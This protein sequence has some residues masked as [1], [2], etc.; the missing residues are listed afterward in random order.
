MNDKQYAMLI[1]EPKSVVI[2]RAFFRKRG[3]GPRMLV[4]IGI[5]AV[6][7]HFVGHAMGAFSAVEQDRRVLVNGDFFRITADAAKGGEISNIE[8]FDGSQWNRLVGGDGQTG[9][10]VSL[11]DPSH[12]YSLARDANGTIQNLR[13]TADEITFQTVGRPYAVGGVASPW[14]VTLSYDIYA[15][16]ALFVDT[17][18]S[19][20]AG[21]TT[22]LTG[23]SMALQVDSTVKDA[24]KYYMGCKKA[25]GF[26]SDRVAFGVNPNGSYTNEVE[27]LV[28]YRTPMGGTTGSSYGGGKY[29][30]TLA[31]GATS[32]G[33]SYRYSNRFS[34]ALG[35]GVTGMGNTGTN[36]VGQRGYDWFRM[37]HTPSGTPSDQI[38]KAPT[39]ARIDQMVANGATFIT[40]QNWLLGGDHNGN[41]H[42]PY[43]ARN[44]ADLVAAI[45]YA[46]QKGLRV[47]F[48]M[49]GIERYGMAQQF[50]EQY[51]TRNWDGIYV[52]WAGAQDVSC[53]EAAY[54][55]TTAIGDA[56]FSTDGSY[57]AAK[58][59]FQFAKQLRNVVGPG[60]LLIAHQGTYNTGI[61]G[62]KYFDAYLNGENS[63]DF[64][65]FANVDAAVLKGMMG[66]GACTP[67]PRSSSFRTPE[68]VAKAAVWG[69]NIIPDLG[70]EDS[71]TWT[72]SD[73]D[74]PDNQ[75]C[76]SY[77]RLLSTIDPNRCT[78][79]N[80]PS[81]NQ[82]AATCSESGF[83]CLVYRERG[84]AG[85]SVNDSYLVLVANLGSATLASDVTLIPS[86]LGMSGEYHIGRV[87]PQTGMTVP[88]GFTTGEFMTSELPVWGFEGYRLVHAPEP[89][90]AALLL[91]AGFMAVAFLWK[92][93][94]WRPQLA[95][96]LRS[97]L[98]L[99][100]TAL[101]MF[102][103]PVAAWAVS[104]S[105]E[106]YPDNSHSTL[107][108][109]EPGAAEYSL[110]TLPLALTSPAN[111]DLGG[112]TY[113]FADQGLYRVYDDD[114]SLVRQTFL[115]GGDAWS[116]AG[117]LSRVHLHG[118]RHNGK[119]LAEKD[120]L[121]R[122]GT[123]LSLTCS[124]ISSY[125]AGHL[126]SL[127]VQT[128]LV[129]TLTLDPWD[130]S[131][132]GHNM[133]EIRDPDQNRWVLCDVDLGNALQ[134]NGHRLNLLDTTDLYRAGRHSQLDVLNSDSLY[135]PLTKYSDPAEALLLLNH[136]V[137]TTQTWYDRMLQVPI[138]NHCFAANSAAE[139]ARV[140]SYPGYA[141]YTWLTP[142]QFRQA[143]YPGEPIYVPEPSPLLLGMSCVLTVGCSSI[144]R[145]V[146]R[147]HA[148]VRCTKRISIAQKADCGFR[149]TKLG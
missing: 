21:R 7:L 23:A 44:E 82:V 65:M 8:L 124:S 55:P 4:R 17:N 34:M 46:H 18:Y 108:G 54:R 43:V 1:R 15:N 75:Y 141:T 31:N 13:V 66:G 128:R 63:D 140:K 58:E 145:R 95:P 59:F 78:V 97:A 136:D 143:F 113:R 85:D 61:M 56:H 147:R 38:D 106:Y 48:Y 11:S 105:V 14:T 84:S 135:D 98:L 117:H 52:D 134:F 133:I 120:A 19:L 60:G 39:N 86:I 2:A 112:T 6:L 99:I 126:Q 25:S 42:D 93:G 144:C 90:P 89:C 130:Y 103:C 35:S 12:Q 41:P 94:S 22:T 101:V 131:D 69:I 47:N 87:D 91:T 9:T 104:Y 76:A 68:A 96:I 64:N 67:Y 122:G 20:D 53:H 10:Q 121:V 62:N 71:M 24:A 77:W 148:P 45:D 73:P 26:Q 33:S 111:V 27:A 138:I 74:D 40:M 116:L 37:E 3:I 137:P 127:G 70:V 92:R 123:P 149:D 118:D 139:A 125:V 49:R 50:F 81:V 119:S 129:Q 28:E 16:G 88:L 115:Y 142:G 30:W 32:L 51:L 5:A 72:T 146:A 110:G 80:L 107:A 36:V 109:S 114:S 83:S 29:T 102:A 57:V 79:Y 132:D 100:A